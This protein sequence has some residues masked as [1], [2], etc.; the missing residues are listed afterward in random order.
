[1]LGKQRCTERGNHLQESA[2]RYVRISL[3]AYPDSTMG[4]P[5]APFKKRSTNHLM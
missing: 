2:G 5:P 4:S 3:T 1:M